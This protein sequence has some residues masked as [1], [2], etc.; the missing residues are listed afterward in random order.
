MLTEISYD[1][2]RKTLLQ[3]RQ[4]SAIE[5]LKEDFYSEYE[6]L[7]KN[8]EEDLQQK[9]SIEKAK[10]VENLRKVLN[11]LK[12]Q[13]LHKLLFKALKDCEMNSGN[14]DGL[15]TEEQSLYEEL[16][17]LLREYLSQAKQNNS[18][19]REK[20]TEK[21]KVKTK[22]SEFVGFDGNNYGPFTEGQ[23]IELPKE[24]ASFLETRQAIEPAGG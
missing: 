18:K 14:K 3:E 9:Y 21:F 23:V 1:E 2:L 10:I 15:I 7:I 12:K 17:T 11:D 13:R 24:I 20:T 4:N 8:R 5:S 19:T 6:S 22:I 16:T